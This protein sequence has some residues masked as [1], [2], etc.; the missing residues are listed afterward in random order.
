MSQTLTDKTSEFEAELSRPRLP[1]PLRMANASLG[2][3]GTRL[4]PLDVDSTVAAARRVAGLH[5][6]GDQEPLEEPLAIL[7]RSMNEDITL[8]PMG[9]LSLHRLIVGSL[10]SRLR[11]QDLVTRHPEVLEQRTPAPMIVT[12]PPRSGTTMTHRLLACDPAWRSAALWELWD[13]VPP[14]DPHSTRPT[15]QMRRILASWRWVSP[16]MD[17]IHEIG[18]DIPEEEIVV[19]GSAFSSFFY[20]WCVGVPQ[21]VQWYREADHTAG[22]QYLRKT[23]QAL[24]WCRPGAD[25]WVLKSPQHLENLRPMLATFPDATVLHNHRDP[26]ATVASTAS[27]M[28]YRARVYFTR[29]DLRWIGALAADLTERL[30][31]ASIRDRGVDD[32]RFVDV[33]FR[34]LCQDPVA[35]LRP[36]YE[37]A[38]LTLSDD[39]ERRMRDWLAENPQ[40]KHG[41]HHYQP[42]TFGLDVDRLRERFAFYYERY[43]QVL[44]T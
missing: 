41:R 18:L 30:L 1:L 24:Q 6:F 28:A 44:R 38:G 40:G 26:V 5:D 11:L 10:V 39:A 14:G 35:A 21:F 9:R 15:A 31:R 13:P 34:P 33:Y 29:P 37:V 25:R 32:A 23:L 7:G 20:E 12:G 42:Q 2:R 16:G 19:L 36:A 27:F 3:L 8:N 4:W 43:P 17:A 22:Y